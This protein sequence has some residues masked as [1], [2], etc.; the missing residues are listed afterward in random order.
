M[1]RT[2]VETL[3]LSA[4]RRDFQS[5]PSRIGTAMRNTITAVLTAAAIAA[6][7]TLLTAPGNP[8]GAGPLPQAAETT[9]RA[10]T[11][12]AWPYLNCVGTPHGNPRIRLVTT[13][14]LG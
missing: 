2:L 11:Q 7:I 3:N 1:V 9:L 14:H 8:V 12:Q 5:S 13:D 10:C 6:L 4:G